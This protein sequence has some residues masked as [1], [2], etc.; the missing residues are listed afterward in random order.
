MQKSGNL[1]GKT[2]IGFQGSFVH[3]ETYTLV[4][5]DPDCGTLDDFMNQNIPPLTGDDITRLWEELLKLHEALHSVHNISAPFA[6]E[7][8]QHT[9]L[10]GWH[11]SLSPFTVM[12]KRGPSDAD[13]DLRFR[14]LDIG[15]LSEDRLSMLYQAPECF[16]TEADEVNYQMADIWSLGC[17]LSEFAVWTS[18]GLS[19]LKDYRAARER[20]CQEIEF[21][22]PGAFHNGRD[23]LSSVRAWHDHAITSKLHD[24]RVTEP[25]LHQLVEEMLC[26]DGDA[27]PSARQLKMKVT[28][29]LNRAREQHLADLNRGDSVASNSTGYSSVG[30]SSQGLLS[31]RASVRSDTSTDSALN[32]SSS[33]TGR[34]E[35]SG[36][37]RSNIMQRD[38]LASPTIDEHKE[39]GFGSTHRSSNV[40]S[41]VSPPPTQRWSNVYSDARQANEFVQELD[42]PDVPIPKPL[43]FGNRNITF[44]ASTL[45]GDDKEIVVSRGPPPA[46]LKRQ[47]TFETVTPGAPRPQIG[48]S[49]QS[50]AEA[51]VTEVNRLQS[52]QR[53]TNPQIMDASA[54][55]TAVL[56]EV[57]L[58]TFE[59]RPDH[60]PRGPSILDAASNPSADTRQDIDLKRSLTTPGGAGLT[61]RKSIDLRRSVSSPSGPKQVD[62]ETSDLTSNQTVKPSVT[63]YK[64]FLD[65]IEGLIW[66]NQKKGSAS[67]ATI[68]DEQYLN[69][70]ADRD[71]V[72]LIDDSMSMRAHREMTSRAVR[73][74]SWLL[75]K[76]DKN[77]MD[78]YFGQ[79]PDKTHARPGHSSD[80]QKPLLKVLDNCKGRSNI[81]ARLTQILQEYRDRNAAGT[82]AAP[83]KSSRASIASIGSTSRT[84]IGAK[85]I[86]IF[87]FTDGNWDAGTEDI[88]KENMA[89]LSATMRLQG[90]PENAVGIQLIYTEP[91]EEVKSRLRKLKSGDYS[92]RF[93]LNDKSLEKVLTLTLI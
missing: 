29:L 51:S 21:A 17:I 61:E 8:K 58:P 48:L 83:Q 34:L 2:I 86:M 6:S 16:R 32:Y 40:V 57:A 27:R 89:A 87:V 91:K 88:L 46:S 69:I 72:F 41:P 12:A 31:H 56:E 37:S 7:I 63:V 50:D 45:N 60:D 1:L 3:D 13:Y 14:L 20:E 35:R 64:P 4:L 24:D 74:L 66:L 49:V 42:S 33:I 10:R 30:L 15:L 11:Q 93:V 54:S 75:K 23:L 71:F 67:S 53:E 82:G 52:V 92:E 5:E 28:R 81:N 76:Y 36:T 68:R 79:K 18:L 80:L 47:E 19:G 55:A 22:I 70:L 26:E 77:G 84:T 78:L 90:A 43:R 59:I 39:M 38:S 25:I 9:L 73:L 65:L 44:D 62:T 85:K